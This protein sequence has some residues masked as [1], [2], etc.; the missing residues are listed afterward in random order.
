MPPRHRPSLGIPLMLAAMVGITAV[1]AIAKHVA[2]SLSGVQVAWGYF[3]FIAITLATGFTIARI[4]PRR[5]LRTRNPGLQLL[6]AGCLVGSLSMLFVSLQYLE[7]ADATVISFAA[8]LFVTALS[9]PVLKERVGPHRWA[10][11]LLGWAGVVVVIR[12][13]LGIV[14]WAAVLPLIGA[15][16]FAGFQLVTRIITACDDHLATLFYTSAGGA[17]LLT[18]AMPVFWQWPAPE[19]WAWMALSG[20]IGAG[21]H[22]LMINAF[23]VTEAS[24]LAPFNYSRIFW[25][26]AIGWFAFQDLPDVAT[27]AGGGL[28]VV[29]GLYVFWREQVSQRRADP[30]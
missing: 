9:W 21:A 19:T 25:A 11:V 28:I 23:A 17:L 16:F 22:F 15:V 24:L 1:D 27:L 14:H 3:T 20:A 8:P 7:L 12:P 6:R 4:P 26:V 13:G 5:W 2:S 29:S 18:L 10:A 30:G